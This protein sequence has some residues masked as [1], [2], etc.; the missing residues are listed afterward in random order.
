[1]TSTLRHNTFFRP[2]GLDDGSDGD[3]VSGDTGVNEV[4]HE[5][6]LDGAGNTPS[7]PPLVPRYLLHPEEGEGGR[8]EGE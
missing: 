2:C 6:T 8:G 5:L 4:A 7:L 1:M 3:H